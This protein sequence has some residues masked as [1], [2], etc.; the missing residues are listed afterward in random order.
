[1]STMVA[2]RSTGVRETVIH[3]TMLPLLSFP[4][5]RKAHGNHGRVDPNLYKEV[6]MH[7]PRNGLILP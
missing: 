3:I 7:G 1:M 2:L 6:D 4:S 5:G